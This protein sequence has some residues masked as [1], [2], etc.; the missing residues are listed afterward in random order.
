MKRLIKGGRILDPASGRDE[1]L[2]LLIEDG[3]IARLEKDMK[4]RDGGDVFDASGL[5]VMPGFIDMHCH[6]REPGYEYK[7]TVATGCAAAVKGGIT[8]LMCMA[9]TDPVNDCASVT[10][11]ILERAHEA[12][13]AKVYPVGCLTKGMRGESL[14]EMGELAAS[15]C[16][17]VSDD[18]RPVPSGEI[19]RRAIA[20]AGIYGLLV[21]DHA[22]DLTIAGDGVMHEGYVSTML[23]LEGIP[24]S[25]AFSEVARNIA[26]IKEFGGRIHIAHVSTAM[27]VGLVRRA[28]AEGLAVTAETCPHYFT[29]DHE[30]VIG[31]D[32]NAKVKPPLRTAEDVEAIIEGLADGAID[33][34]ATDHAP[35][36]A[37]EKQVEFDLA[38][39]GIS[40]LET[41]FALTMGLVHGGRI[42][43]LQAVSKWTDAPAAVTGIRG[44]SLGVGEPADVV[45]AD[46]DAQWRVNPE[47]FLS[48]GRNS[49]FAGMEVRG[50]VTATFV[51]GRLVYTREK[52]ITGK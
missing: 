51:D 27:V 36:H 28:K 9:N 25:A 14:S 1:I 17:A 2:D 15:G 33:V 43:I 35:H 48:R 49:P 47:E 6:L 40:G 38:A 16:I 21:I 44:G 37:D 3:R 5:A 32:T 41:A 23:G 42:P 29:L 12:G 46:L 24:A 11:H 19:M 10:T 7:E 31:Y 4:D 18:G 30:A 45:I 39:F 20:Y 22:E 26:L 34:I 13:L 52:G 50:Q 8:S